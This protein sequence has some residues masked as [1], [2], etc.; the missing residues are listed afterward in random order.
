[1]FYKIARAFLFAISKIFYRMEIIGQ[2]NLPSTG[3]VIVV[4]NHASLMDP[5][6]M[7]CSLKRQVCF[8]AKDQLF[9]VPFLG[10]IIRWLGAFPV[11]RGV[12]DRGA[13]SSALRVLAQERVLGIFPE[14]RR[15]KDGE[16]HPLRPG[17]ALLAMESGSPILPM[18]IVNSH[19]LRALRFPK[20]R[21]II[22]AP[23]TI[24]SMKSRKE[25]VRAGTEEI[26]TEIVALKERG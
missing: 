7:G 14:G 6:F 2:E 18:Y 11:K 19:R 5:I 25:T 16:I 21:V 12:G 17:A 3:S 1:M 15:Y 23:I 22:G 4:A 9:K 8:M 20:I 26:Y 13:L 24:K 10:Q